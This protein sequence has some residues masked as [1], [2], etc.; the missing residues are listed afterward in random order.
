MELNAFALNESVVKSGLQSTEETNDGGEGSKLKEFLREE[1]KEERGRDG[2]E[3]EEDEE[4]E[5]EVREEEEEE[6]KS[7]LATRRE[8][9]FGHPPPTP[10][11]P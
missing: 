8:E 5:E 3:E 1:R 9:G 10:E 4:E 11:G 6:W 2:G 7:G